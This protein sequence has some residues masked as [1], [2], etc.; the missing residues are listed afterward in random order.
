MS[1]ILTVALVC[2]GLAQG[3]PPPG[4]PSSG[5]SASPPTPPPSPPPGAGGRRG[6]GPAGLGAINLNPKDLTTVKG[7]VEAGEAPQPLS[8]RSRRQMA[9]HYSVSLKTDTGVITV[10]LG[11]S[12]YLNQKNFVPQPGERLEVKGWKITRNNQPMIV[13]K[14]IKSG[15]KALTLRD[16]QGIPAW[17]R[18]G[19]GPR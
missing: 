15:G 3:P 4:A 9:M 12:W 1:I 17:G 7:V 5:P 8:R 10:H 2:P 19:G 11:P 16:D 18:R 14:E 6:M 13:A